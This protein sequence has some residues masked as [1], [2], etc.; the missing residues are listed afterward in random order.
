MSGNE[1]LGGYAL[2]NASDAFPDLEHLKREFDVIY[3]LDLCVG[4]EA[5]VLYDELYLTRIGPGAGPILEPLT[6]EGVLSVVALRSDDPMAAAQEVMLR[7]RAAELVSRLGRANVWHFDELDLASTAVVAATGLP[8]DLA[9][10]EQTGVPLVLPFRQMPIYLTLPSIERERCA[11]HEA[12]LSLAS[13]YDDLKKAIMAFRLEEAVDDVDSLPIPPIALS[14]LSR[15]DTFDHL[16][17]IVL[18][19]RKRFAG[20]RK[21]LG[22]AREVFA[23]PDYSMRERYT[24]KLQIDSDLARVGGEVRRVP[25]VMEFIG[26]AEKIGDAAVPLVAAN[27]P[28]KLHKAAGT[29]AKWWDEKW[30]RF[31]M[32]P[33]IGVL[34]FYTD[35][36]ARQMAEV[37]KLLFGRELTA[38]DVTRARKYAAAVAKYVP[39]PRKSA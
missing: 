17:E 39:P 34:D 4:I 36:T 15:A 23:S 32:R 10:E 1:D 30:F 37:T 31:R 24:R 2:V 25:S 9:L 5:A 13:R 29:V 11:L 14:V 16:G 19:E 6:R 35:A 20:L 28:T 22:E 18:E 21:R 26:D 27:D 12:K 8:A 7:P 38:A 3:F 33:L